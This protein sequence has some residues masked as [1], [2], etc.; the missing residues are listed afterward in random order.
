MQNLDKWKIKEM[1]KIFSQY[2]IN[3]ETVFI[4]YCDSSI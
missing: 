4:N 2:C 1:H 3:T